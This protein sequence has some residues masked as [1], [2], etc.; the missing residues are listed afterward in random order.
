M[1]ASY[2]FSAISALA[3]LTDVVVSTTISPESSR[4]ALPTSSN[5]SSSSM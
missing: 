1:M 4:N 3:P 5:A 2:L